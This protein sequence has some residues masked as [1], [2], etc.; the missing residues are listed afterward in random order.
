MKFSTTLAPRTLPNGNKVTDE[1][2]KN[3]ADDLNA[4]GTI[5][6]TDPEGGKHDCK[7]TNVAVTDRGVEATIEFPFALPT[8]KPARVDLPTLSMGCRIAEPPPCSICEA[9][10]ES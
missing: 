4:K 8:D 10:K 9:E 5:V 3:V 1:A 6:V 2:L 7:V